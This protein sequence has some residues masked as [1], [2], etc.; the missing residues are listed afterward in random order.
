L[1]RL[2]DIMWRRWESTL[3]GYT[4]IASLQGNIIAKDSR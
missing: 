1:Q 4:L 2:D 3:M